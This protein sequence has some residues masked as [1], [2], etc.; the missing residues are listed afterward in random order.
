MKETKT[1]KRLKEGKKQRQK[2]RQKQNNRQDGETVLV[3]EKLKQSI[4][5]EN[6]SGDAERLAERPF[7]VSTL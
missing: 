2:G 6:S 4:M 1:V 5:S 7:V 3:K